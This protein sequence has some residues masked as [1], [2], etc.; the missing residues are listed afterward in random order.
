MEPEESFVQCA[1]REV[2][3]E[4]GLDVCNLKL[5]GVK[6]FQNKENARYIVYYFKTKDFSGEIQASEEGDVFWVKR[7]ELFTYKT[8]EDFEKMVEVFE[9]EELN[10]NIYT[11]DAEGKWDLLSI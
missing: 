10:E 7:S 8:V 4:T 1:I 6:Q 2:K 11:R 5:C 9:A 3:E